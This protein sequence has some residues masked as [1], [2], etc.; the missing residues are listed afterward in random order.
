[1]VRHYVLIYSSY[2]AVISVDELNYKQMDNLRM[3]QELDLFDASEAIRRM[4]A[5]YAMLSNDIAEG[6]L[7]GVQ[8]K[9]VEEP[10]PPSSY[11]I[12]INPSS[13]LSPIDCLAMGRHLMNQSR[14]TIAEQWI[15]AGIK[16]QDRKGPQTEMILLRGPTKAELFRTLGKVRFERSKFK[17]R[18]TMVLLGIHFC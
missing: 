8:Y 1:V 17:K 9:Y 11:L 4:Q 6:F 18:Q 12:Y 13:K 14:W 15:L 7:D 5:T 3:P 10:F 2:N 16:A